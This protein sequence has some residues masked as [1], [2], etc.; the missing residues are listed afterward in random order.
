MLSQQRPESGA[1]RGVGETEDRLCRT[2]APYLNGH[3]FST[4]PSSPPALQDNFRAVRG[5]SPADELRSLAREVRRIGCG[6]R[7]DPETIAAAKSEIAYRLTGLA[8]RLAG[9]A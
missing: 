1:L 8:R 9:A 4:P 2:A 5:P 6:L 7:C 3:R